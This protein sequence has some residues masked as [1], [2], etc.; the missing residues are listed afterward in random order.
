VFEKAMEVAGINDGE[1]AKAEARAAGRRRGVGFANY[2]EAAPGPPEYM[3]H[4]LPGM[5]PIVKEPAHAVLEADGSVTVHTQQVP[6]GQGHETTLAQLTADELG[7]RL[8]AVE[9]RYGDTRTQPF[10]LIGTAGSRAA[11]MASGAVL[12]AGRALR[13]R[14]VDLAADL[15]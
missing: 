9:I 3:D 6:H 11:T 1:A 12:L 7:V 8:D 2:I 13:E 10:G 4:A 15:L 5:S 14:I